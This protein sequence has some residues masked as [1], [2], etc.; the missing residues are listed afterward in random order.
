MESNHPGQ[1]ATHSQFL[2]QESL[3][4]EENRHQTAEYEEPYIQQTKVRQ[5][6]KALFKN[7]NMNQ[8]I[9]Y[10]VHNFTGQTTNSNRQHSDKM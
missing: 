2:D 1:N 4:S 10:G 7:A 8:E 9:D 6:G 3:V 5:H